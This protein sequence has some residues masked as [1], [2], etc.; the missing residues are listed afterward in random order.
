MGLCVSFN[1]TSNVKHSK[2]DNL[3]WVLNYYDRVTHRSAEIISQDNETKPLIARI[4]TGALSSR[5]DSQQ[6]LRSYLHRVWTKHHTAFFSTTKARLLIGTSTC[7]PNIFN[8]KVNI[9]QLVLIYKI[10]C[11]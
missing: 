6:E 1:G 8:I 3:C 11:I 9:E 7:K 5:M 10:Q 4:S 2:A